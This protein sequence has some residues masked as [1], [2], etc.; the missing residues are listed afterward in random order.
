MMA[1]DAKSYL[2]KVTK[3]ELLL[4]NKREYLLQLQEQLYSPKSSYSNLEK[5]QKSKENDL[6]GKAISQIEE[7]RE[8]IND[9]II[10]AL[11]YK[12]EVISNLEKL[13]RVEY[14]FLYKKYIMGM[15]MQE[16]ANFYYRSYSWATTVHAR[17]IKSLQKVLDEEECL[18]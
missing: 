11:K 10:A 7:I 8:Q 2:I 15:D 5:V 6:M 4:K 18:K 17:A 1:V 14:D 13:K 3:E 12:Q 9:E 16:I